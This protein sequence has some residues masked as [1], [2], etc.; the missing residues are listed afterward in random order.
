M[1]D[2]YNRKEL[3][4]NDLVLPKKHKQMVESLV[5][6][7]PLGSKPKGTGS[8]TKIGGDRNQDRRNDLVRGKGKGLVIL[9]HGEPGVGKTTTAECVAE[10][11]KRPLFALTCG[12]W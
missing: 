7:M 9:L 4:S 10:Y 2:V 5:T 3:F 6:M 12:K 8:K 11:T 1:S